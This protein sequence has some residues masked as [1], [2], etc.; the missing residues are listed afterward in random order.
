M[1]QSLWI[2]ALLLGAVF[3]QHGFA[4][5]YTIN[6]TTAG[7]SGNP[8]PS[9]SFTY[10]ASAPLG[11]QFTDFEV[12]WDGFSLDLTNSANNPSGNGCG[13]YNSA[14]TFAFLNGAVP[15]T[16]SGEAPSWN[17]GTNSPPPI[18]SGVFSFDDFG[19][20][21]ILGTTSFFISADD[22]IPGSSTPQE[23]AFAYGTWSLTDITT[24]E[25]SY[26]ILMA[27]GLLAVACVGRRRRAQGLAVRPPE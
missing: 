5:T 17:S 19:P 1:K 12:A 26:L 24:P 21:S 22:S 15:C 14:A 4:D 3:A 27:T 2:V 11:S 9:G 7:G 10:D 20:I 6:F 16:P 13:S 8:A 25:P 23:Y 18:T